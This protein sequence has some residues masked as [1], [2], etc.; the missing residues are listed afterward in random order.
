MRCFFTV[1]FLGALAGCAAL[2]ESDSRQ[3]E[4]FLAA[5]GFV[6]KP[7]T[8]AQQQAMMAALTPYKLQSRIRD[9]AVIYLYPDPSENIVYVGGPQEYSAYQKMS[10]QQEMI[11][12]QQMTALEYQTMNPWMMPT[13]YQFHGPAPVRR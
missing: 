9:G 11:N 8:T 5:A 7:V 13:Y 6:A 1:L 3:T 12:Q 2:R 4:K 10:L